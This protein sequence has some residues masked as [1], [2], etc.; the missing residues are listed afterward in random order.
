MRFVL[1]LV[2]F[3]IWSYLITAQIAVIQ[4]ISCHGYSDAVLLVVPDF[5]TGEYVYQWNTG[6][7]TP[8]L[9]NVG[10]GTYEV[11]VLDVPTNDQQVYSIV[12]H[13][14]P[15]VTIHYGVQN[16]SCYGF[17][18]GLI[19]STA[20]GFG[21][22]SYLWSTG[23]NTP[24]IGNLAAGTYS[25]TVTDSKGCSA[26]ETITISEPQPISIST[27]ITP[28][29]CD[30]H[31]DGQVQLT[32]LGGVPFYLYYW[33]EIHFDS[34]YTTQHLTN[35]RG[36]DYE[37]TITDMNGC[38]F[39]D[40]IH[41]PT[42]YV[43]P[44][45]ISAQ[46]YVCNGLH[47]A[48]SIWAPLADTGV[49]YHYAWSSQYN[50]GTFWTNDSVYA[51]SQS[52]PAGAYSVT[53]TDPNGCQYYHNGVIIESDAPMVVQST[54]IHNRCYGDAQ[55]SINI[56]V[57]GGDPQP[58]YTITWTGPNG[59]T[60]N[61]FYIANLYSGD[62]T[63][64]VT[65]NVVCTSTGTIRIEPLTPLQGYIAAQ[66][67]ECP[68]DTT[69]WA[70]A[71]YHG[72]TGSLSYVWSNGEQT[73]SIY[74]LPIGTYTLTVTDQSGCQVIDTLRIGARRYTCF[75]IP[76]LITL[77]NDGFNDVFQVRGMCGFEEFQVRIY[78]DWG[79][80]VYESRD[81]NFTW[82]P[83]DDNAQA[84][85][86]YYCYISVV[87]DGKPYEFKTSLTILK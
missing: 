20:T 14:P 16:V 80:L 86:V 45:N 69:G 38:V 34:V 4:D 48:V 12:L 28:S 75:V 27:Q 59:F 33:R 77:N 21:G 79:K 41:V 50:S 87:S 42:T 84:H 63:Y 29:S 58:S 83:A 53:V 6:A 18:D 51:I 62:Y 44:V 82:N 70:Q 60:S 78:T 36:G 30:G 40:T 57:T 37:L 74:A 64:V 7:F 15:P 3:V 56:V 85:Q 43:V 81:C 49:Y 65:D 35:V 52:F 17:S 2:C 46:S 11:T 71:I 19:W 54:V 76:N 67:V 66:D 13:D 25:L 31:N 68:G 26:T 39:Q 24:T 1:S 61:G 8:L 73:S 22:L 55:G 9:Q 5:G 32:V 10:A 72:G 23:E 47:G